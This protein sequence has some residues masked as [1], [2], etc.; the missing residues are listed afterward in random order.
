[1]NYNLE[2]KKNWNNKANR[3]K[4]D[5]N[6]KNYNSSNEDKPLNADSISSIAHMLD[7]NKKDN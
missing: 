3:S 6:S 4:K 7:R 5:Y 2:M 1:M